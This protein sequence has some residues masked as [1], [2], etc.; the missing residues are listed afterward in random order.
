[1]ETQRNG[2][3]LHLFHTSEG[4]SDVPVCRSFGLGS[5]LQH[6]TVPPKTLGEDGE[7]ITECEK[8]TNTQRERP[9]LS[10]EV[11][12]LNLELWSRFL[13]FRSNRDDLQVHSLDV[14]RN[15]SLSIEEIV[16]RP[17]RG[18]WTPDVSRSFRTEKGRSSSGGPPSSSSTNY[19][20]PSNETS[21]SKQRDKTG[22]RTRRR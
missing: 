7:S 4:P 5:H 22:G 21:H 10:F 17:R 11:L 2:V 12:N 1:M 19:T 15:W 14:L 16:S 3:V 20:S 8:D 13:Q 18:V 6:H 9:V